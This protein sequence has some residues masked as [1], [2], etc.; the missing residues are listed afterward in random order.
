MKKEHEQVK[1]M[2][3]RT[4]IISQHED[5]LSFAHYR[6]PYFDFMV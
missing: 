3:I 4:F 6:D 5:L 2:D 1:G